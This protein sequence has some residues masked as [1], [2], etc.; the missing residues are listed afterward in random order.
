MSERGRLPTFIPTAAPVA[1]DVDLIPTAAP[2]ADDGTALI[3][4]LRGRAPTHNE[5]QLLSGQPIAAGSTN[6]DEFWWIWNYGGGGYRPVL[7]VRFLDG[8][9]YGY[10]GVPLPVA[11]DFITTDSH[12]RFVWNR[13]R[14]VYPL[15]GGQAI[16]K[17][18]SSN[19]RKPQVVRLHNK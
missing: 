5:A 18:D 12:G 2:V 14:D 7:Y 3:P 10:V 15:L 6:V 8:G 17:G 13:L 1:A 16:K 19:R 11:V 4:E 9:L